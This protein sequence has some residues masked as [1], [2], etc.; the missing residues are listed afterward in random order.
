VIPHLLSE[1]L[2]KG[3]SPYE[4]TEATIKRLEGSFALAI[5]F[6][7]EKEQLIV[8]R[9][10]SPLAIGLNENAY[11]VA[12]DANAL[13]KISKR[14][15]Y[16]EDGDIAILRPQQITVF[17]QGREVQRKTH[18]IREHHYEFGKNGHRHF[19]HKEIVEQPLV[20]TKTLK[21]FWHPTLQQFQMTASMPFEFADVERIYIVACG[22]SYHAA[23]VAKYWLEAFAN[24]PV[25]VDI[26]SEFRY[27]KT[28]LLRGNVAIFI[29]QSGE[30]ADTLAA[31]RHCR[32]QGLYV[33][34]I[35][36]VAE[37]SI[38]RESD[39]TLYTEAGPE[40][41]VASTKA[42]T[43]QLTVLACL[44][45]IAA[46]SRGCLTA[47]EE[48]HL[49]TALWS[50]PDYVTAVLEQEEA[51]AKLAEQ[52]YQARDVLYLGRGSCYP[53]ALEGALKLKEISYIHAEGYAAG[54]MKHGPIALIDSTVPIIVLAPPELFDKTTSNLQE[55]K[56]RGGKII[57]FSHQKGMDSLAEQ[58]VGG[59]AMPET[60]TFIAPLIYSIPI[61][62]LAYHAAVLKNTDVDQPRNLAKSVTVE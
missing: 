57:L 35:V 28:P 19:M 47:K 26:A 40:V 60:E 23:M 3:L 6:A 31:L 48:A 27:R 22:T 5:L 62:L 7:Q 12:S 1:Y 17:Q 18:Q 15:I 52:V 30:T 4:A 50:V 24:L 13:A 59:L 38:A 44:T 54:E 49:S 10:Y 34:S 55:V 25:E 51:L 32:D 16:L 45:L 41:G 42:F 39:V 2:K 46:R 56:A 58:I 33:L 29:S 11:Y 61:Q 20:I 36:N 21:N 8:A 53:I 37:S 43:T 14:V 9:Q